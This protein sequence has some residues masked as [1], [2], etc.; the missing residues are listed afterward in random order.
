MNRVNK[1][2]LLC[3]ANCKKLKKGSHVKL[4]NTVRNSQAGFSLIE[5]M[6]V[7]AIIGILAAVGIPQFAKF[8]SKARQSEAKASLSGLYSSEQSFLGDNSTYSADLLAIGFAVSGT[9]LRYSTGFSAG[10]PNAQSQV[11]AVN[12]AGATFLPAVAATAALVTYNFTGATGV[13][14]GTNIVTAGT[15]FI[16]AAVGDPRNAAAALT[17]ATADVWTINQAKNITNA[18]VGL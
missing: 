6:V 1:C 5:L 11:A 10:S 14:A 13:T 15:S 12:T 4:N 8:Q 16:A 3:A 17:A 18:R 2:G 9:N 7:V